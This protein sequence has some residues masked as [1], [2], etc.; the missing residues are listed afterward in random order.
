[1]GNTIGG[2][3]G[4]GE[5]KRKKKTWRNKNFIFNK[6]GLGSFLSQRCGIRYF[7]LL[8]KLNDR[9]F[10]GFLAF[11]WPVVQW[12]TQQWPFAPILSPWNARFSLVLGRY[13][14]ALGQQPSWHV[15]PCFQ[16]ISHTSPLH[17][18]KN[19][20]WKGSI[21]HISQSIPHQ[22]TTYYTPYQTTSYHSVLYHF[23]SHTT[24]FQNAPRLASYHSSK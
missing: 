1:M 11:I 18:C 7:A 15:P 23:T 13:S 20:K 9:H 10:A 14:Y 4:G 8:L 16:Q 2:G 3:G 22:F 24:P 21:H 12:I 17:M 19:P 6:L 5:K